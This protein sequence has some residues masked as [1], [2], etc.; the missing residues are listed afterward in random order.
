M[1]FPI[2]LYNRNYKPKPCGA[3][4]LGEPG[5]SPRPPPVVISIPTGGGL[6]LGLGLGLGRY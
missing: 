3:G 4:E 2:V 1:C 6:G 5:G